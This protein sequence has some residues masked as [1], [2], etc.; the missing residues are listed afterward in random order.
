MKINEDLLP[1]VWEKRLIW[2]GSISG[3]PNNIT[4]SEPLV[5]GKVLI[6]EWLYDYTYPVF[7]PIVM[8][9][10]QGGDF[11]I[12]TYTRWMYS[13]TYKGFIG[14]MCRFLSPN[15]NLTAWRI[16]IHSTLVKEGETTTS[17]DS[18]RLVK[19]WAFN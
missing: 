15:A 5:S 11:E 1:N 12:Y 8:I 3:F 2:S 4:F 7:S 9:P 19:V 6:L 16:D 17:S 10:Q 13:G 14:S 18:M